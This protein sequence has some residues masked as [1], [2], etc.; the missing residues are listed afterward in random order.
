MAKESK[1][2][3]ISSL[4]DRKT[5]LAKEDEEVGILQKEAMALPDKSQEVQD[6]VQNISF[7]LIDLQTA[8]RTTDEGRFKKIMVKIAKRKKEVVSELKRLSAAEKQEPSKIQEDIKKIEAVAPSGDKESKEFENDYVDAAKTLEDF[9]TYI[10]NHNLEEGKEEILKA[11]NAR[12]ESML[13]VVTG[14]NP[15]L[16]NYERFKKVSTQF[17][18]DVKSL[19]SPQEKP[20]L[21]PDVKPAQ[22]QPPEEGEE[23]KKYKYRYDKAK[24]DLETT[25]EFLKTQ[26]TI[27]LKPTVTGHYTDL[28]VKLKDLF[29]AKNYAEFDKVYTTFKTDFKNLKSLETDQKNKKASEPDKTEPY[30]KDEGVE[31]L[32]AAL[33]FRKEDMEEEVVPPVSSFDLSLS[34]PLIISLSKSKS[35]SCL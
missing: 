22:P 23:A 26:T 11:F 12:L 2:Q 16:K 24:K 30:P 1:E 6:L 4:A 34:L 10:K 29:A 32:A 28:L 5:L 13:E 8:Q 14:T 27:K 17:I 15:Q 33:G 19:Y 9:K 21:I 3:R 35:A 31:S 18:A 7:I 20:V 25:L